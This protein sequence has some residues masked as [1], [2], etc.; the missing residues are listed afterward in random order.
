M[1]PTK[2]NPLP[3][4][5]DGPDRRTAV[6]TTEPVKLTTF[7]APRRR[8]AITPPVSLR[9]FIER[10]TDYADVAE[11]EAVDD[12][13]DD[14]ERRYDERAH[15]I[16]GDAYDDVTYD[17]ILDMRDGDDE[18]PHWPVRGLR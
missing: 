3:T 9:D 15:S 13:D 16:T 7:V 4:H 5:H 1:T 12:W 11:P 18:I 17:P 10:D 6:A 8:T 2:R 14:D